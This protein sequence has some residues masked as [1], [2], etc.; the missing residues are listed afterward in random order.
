ME[1]AKKNSK[2]SC[3]EHRQSARPGSCVGL[4]DAGIAHGLLVK[5]E[6]NSVSQGSLLEDE[7]MPVKKMIKVEEGA[8][9]KVE[10][11]DDDQIKEEYDDGAQWSYFPY[12]NDGDG[13]CGYEGTLDPNDL[14][15]DQE[16]GIIPSETGQGMLE[17]KARQDML[18]GQ[19]KADEK[20]Y[21]KGVDKKTYQ[22]NRAEKNKEQFAI[23][24]KAW[25]EKNKQRNWQVCK[26][27]RE[28]NAEKIGQMEK[29]WR[30]KN[31]E[32]ISKDSKAWYLENKEKHAQDRRRYRENNPEKCHEYEK[33]K[34]Q[35]KKQKSLRIPG[36]GNCDRGPP[37]RIVRPKTF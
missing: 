31:K 35:R 24:N 36:F 14:T 27:Y 5:R 4:S 28:K 32:K 9:V 1:Y 7:L 21:C 2:E 34:W 20:I 3:G 26:A 23:R 12:Q 30:D 8:K 18:G 33:K 29:A 19:E 17:V 6:D 16:P 11:D 37:F 13:S 25:I 15:A 22:R 10:Y